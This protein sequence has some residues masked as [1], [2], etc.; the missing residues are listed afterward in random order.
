MRRI[1]VAAFAAM[2]AASSAIAQEA[3]EFFAET[4]PEHALD[5]AMTLYGALGGD[6]AQL[7]EK[8]RELVA[9]GVA[10]QVPCD[11]CIYAHAKNARRAGATEAEVREAVAVA[12]NVRM[13]S[14][15]LNGMAYDFETFK[16]QHDEIAPPMN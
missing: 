7:E 5:E 3:P 1:H 13:W 12:A 10:A 14:T 2:L 11:Y 6:E 9:L 16:A 15:V 8:T 4:Y